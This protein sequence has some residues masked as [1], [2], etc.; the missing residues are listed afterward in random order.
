MNKNVKS[1]YSKGL[2]THSWIGKK[3]KRMINVAI[4][5]LKI[6]CTQMKNKWYKNVKTRKR[7]L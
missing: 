3:T 7:Y 4:Y 5:K 1:V 6:C 2:S